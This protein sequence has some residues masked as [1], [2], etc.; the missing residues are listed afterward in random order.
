MKA[1]E[2]LTI[3]VRLRVNR[4]EIVG[5]WRLRILRAVALLLG[6]PLVVETRIPPHP[7]RSEAWQNRFGGSV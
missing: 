2:T 6:I 1:L 4:S 5:L 3:E 7:W